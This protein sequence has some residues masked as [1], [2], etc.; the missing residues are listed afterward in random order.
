MYTQKLIK[1]YN[2]L[3]NLLPLWG[4]KELDAITVTSGDAS[5]GEIV[6]FQIK[7]RQDGRVVDTRFKVFGCGYIIALV[8]WFSN[9]LKLKTLTYLKEK[10]TVSF[11]I[12]EFKLPKEKRH[13]AVCLLDVIDNLFNKLCEK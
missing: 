11:L 10:V 13:C 8:V 1:Y 9:I 12:E 2:S 6:V 7:K 3:D 5:S 4:A